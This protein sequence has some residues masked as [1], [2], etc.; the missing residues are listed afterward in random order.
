VGNTF[1]KNPVRYLIL[2]N[3]VLVG[4][5]LLASEAWLSFFADQEV[6][7]WR[8]V[9]FCRGAEKNN[10]ILLDRST[11]RNDADG[12]YKFDNELP[13]SRFYQG[14]NSAGFTGHDLVPISTDKPKILFIGDSHTFGIAASPIQEKRFTSLVERAGYFTYNTGIGGL[15]VVQYGLIANK[16]IPLLKTDYVALMLYLG[17]DINTPPSPVAPGK[18]LFFNTNFGGLVRGYDDYGNYFNSVAEA[19]DQRLKLHCQASLDPRLRFLFKSRLIDNLYSFYINYIKSFWNT[20]LTN[21]GN[22]WI[23]RTINDI[24]DLARQQDSK[25]LLFAIPQKNR[26]SKQEIEED[27]RFLRDKGFDPLYPRTLEITDFQSRGGHMLNS[28]HKKYADFILDILAG[29]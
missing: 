10:Y 24:A 13:E 5:V 9:R 22:A 28:G 2:I 27:I 12:I 29:Q 17:N 19:V 11:H 3:I 20:K 26:L 1:E 21:D 23:A 18:F 14:Y 4:L 6:L 16:Y 8:A 15:D 7:G 25:F